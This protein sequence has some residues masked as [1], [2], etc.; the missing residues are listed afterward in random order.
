MSNTVANVYA[1]CTD[2]PAGHG[3]EALVYDAIH[4]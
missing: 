3:C 2:D 4:V 1:D